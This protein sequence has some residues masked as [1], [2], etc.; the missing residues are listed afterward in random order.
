MKLEERERFIREMLEKPN[1]AEAFSW[2][3]E[4]TDDSFRT[5]GESETNEQSIDLIHEIYK[6]GA[7]EVTAVEID[8]Y[9]DGDENT[10]KL[11]ITL[12]DEPEKRRR[13]LEWCSRISQVQGFAAHEDYGQRHVFVMLD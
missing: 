3:D 8:K 7:V 4:C 12:P 2:L 13:V 6:A 9:P 11:V 10:G 1:K 5:V